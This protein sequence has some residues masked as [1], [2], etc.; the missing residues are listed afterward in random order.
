MHDDH[1]W[2]SRLVVGRGLPEKRVGLY[3]EQPYATWRVVGIERWRH[4]L[5]RLALVALRTSWARSRQAP[6]MDSRLS[7]REGE[8]VRS[9]GDR[10][11]RRRKQ[12]AIEAYGS[13]VR[14]FGSWV[15]PAI[16]VYERSWGGEGVGWFD[17]DRR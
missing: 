4:I 15:R 7:T 6:K 11:D 3:V 12:M 9:S 17:A 10:A 8:W 16:T 14:A 13:Q 1:L 2:L 5:P